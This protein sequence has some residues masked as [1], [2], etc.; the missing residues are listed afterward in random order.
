MLKSFRTRRA[1]LVLAI[2]VAATLGGASWLFATNGSDSRSEDSP[3]VIANK[4]ALAASGLAIP[5]AGISGQQLLDT[6]TQSRAS[7]A[8]VDDAIDIFASAGTPVVAAAG[9]T[10]ERLSVSEAG[11]GLTIHLRSGD[12]RRVYYY[13]HLQ[14]YTSGLREG[15]KVA[16]GE[17]IGRVGSTGNASA[18]APHLHFAIKQMAPGESWWQGMA[19]NP[20]PLLTGLPSGAQQGTS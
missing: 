15:Q 17:V 19:V 16:R 1:A 9:G 6:Y 2:A 13:A 12:Q 8:G 14:N 11:D 3:R 4:V 7:G 18:R 10:V 5:V 20:Y